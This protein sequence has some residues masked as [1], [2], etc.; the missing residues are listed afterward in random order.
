MTHRGSEELASRKRMGKKLKTRQNRIP[1][2]S[3]C[4]QVIRSD[5]DWL[6]YD[7]L[8]LGVPAQSP[9][10]P[11]TRLPD[12][13]PKPSFNSHR[14]VMSRVI[15]GRQRIA[16]RFL[17][18]EVPDLCKRLDYSKILTKGEKTFHDISWNSFLKVVLESV[19]GQL[20]NQSLLTP[21]FH[22]FLRSAVNPSLCQFLWGFAAHGH[23]CLVG[24]IFRWKLHLT[25]CQ[26]TQRYIHA[27]TWHDSCSPPNRFQD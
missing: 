15:L 5:F 6:C 13:K 27:G 1:L 11:Q 26:N 21:V 2:G 20:G 25:V 9:T 4:F 10:Q 22:V 19:P 8:M 14:H 23:D 17:A 24:Y 12:C 16:V 18:V 7:C 3:T